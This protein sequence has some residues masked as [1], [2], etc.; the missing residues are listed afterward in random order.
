M[1]H[2]PTPWKWNVKAQEIQAAPL[3]VG[4]ASV[5]VVNPLH[6]DNAPFIV[7]AVNAHQTM[8]NALRTIREAFIPTMPLGA[9]RTQLT[10]VVDEA[11]AKAEGK[12]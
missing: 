10:L 8:V 3:N 1:N 5:R 6:P 2:T 4:I 9:D 12:S 11:I 7:R